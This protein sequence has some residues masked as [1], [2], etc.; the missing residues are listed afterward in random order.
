[1]SWLGIQI[2]WLALRAT[3]VAALAGALLLWTGRRHP[4]SAVVLGAGAMAVLAIMTIVGFCPLPESL[5]WAS[6]SAPKADN[7]LDGIEREISN[8]EDTLE[9]ETRGLNFE[10]LRWLSSLHARSQDSDAGRLAWTA[11]GFAYLTGVIVASTRLLVGWLALCRL[12]RRIR[13]IVDPDLIGQFDAIRASLGCSPKV[14]VCESAVPGLTVTFGW[15]RPLILLP[16]EWR[17]WTMDERGAVLAHELAHVHHRDYLIGFLT[18]ICQAIHFYHP[19]VHWLSAQ[20]RWRQELAADSEAAALVESRTT[21]W[22]VLARMA[23]RLPA[24]KPAGTIL[25]LPAVT[26]GS[27]VRRIQLLRGKEKRRPFSR[28]THIGLV[29]ALAGAALLLSGLR[30]PVTPAIAQEAAEK[31]APYELGYLMPDA[32]G[33]A[34][35]RPSVWCRQPGVD[36]F[37]DT[38]TEQLK[39][40][41]KLGFK[42]PDDLKPQNIEEVVANLQLMTAGTGKPGSRGITL[43][44]SSLMLRMNKEF[45]WPT[46]VRSL[47]PKVKMKETRHDQTT[48]YHLGLV[49][50]LGPM[51][52]SFFMPDKRTVVFFADKSQDGIGKVLDAV[53]A[54]RKRDWGSGWK[55]V[56]NAPFAVVMEYSG[57]HAP[58][59]F[60]KDLEDD[61]D[62]F[63][64]LER[65]R[66]ATLGIELGDNRPV[67]LILDTKSAAAAA[68]VE[69]AA[70]RLCAKELKR[71]KEEAPPSE[72]AEKIWQKL[73]LEL[74]QSRQL[75]R[76]G[77]RLSWE[78]RSS[79]RVGDLIGDKGYLIG[80][81][82]R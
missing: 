51:P 2:A 66:F 18:R 80:T 24:G 62:S 6:P 60:A 31:P 30:G 5:H 39:Q 49:A 40:L 12:R 67:R 44:T 34:A 76:D 23:L 3:L 64:M 82:K 20:A 14:R 37:L 50:V 61:R 58:K 21:Y 16:P 13:A 22:K 35:I 48:V 4:R 75:S 41:E 63:A 46:F 7:A 55:D 27:I 36:K 70:D 69:K 8:A 71:A 42:L 72:P 59:F 38:M 25:A 33:F 10:M 29:A 32:H 74:L 73:G 79:V 57:P 47:A 78:A 17:T 28:M 26:G 53:A 43:G 9:L 65:L 11:L 77:S 19:L 81:E 52:V 15:R 45:D 1:M 54:A 68:E 56:Q